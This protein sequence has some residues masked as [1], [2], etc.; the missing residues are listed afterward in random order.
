MEYNSGS[1]KPGLDWKFSIL[2]F[3]DVK[4]ATEKLKKGEASHIFKSNDLGTV[5]RCDTIQVPSNDVIEDYMVSQSMDV[6]DREKWHC[7][8]IYDGH[9]GPQTAA[10]LSHSLIPYVERALKSG[11]KAG[12][13]I[14]NAVKAAF[15]TLDDEM[16]KD[17]IAA[18]SDAATH[19]EV[20]AR[21]APFYAGSCALLAIYSPTTSE[22]TVAHV[23]DSRAVLG[24]PSSNGSTTIPLSADHTPYN[25]QELER[26]KTKHPNQNDLVISRDGDC[27]RYVGIAV[28]RAF[29]D[30]RW[31]WPKE[32]LKTCEKSFSG[33]P[34]PGNMRDPPY[35]EAEPD[36]K[37]IS[38]L[39][40]DFLILASDGLWSHLS[41]EDAVHAISLWTNATKLESLNVAGEGEEQAQGGGPAVLGKAEHISFWEPWK[42]GRESFVVE[43]ENAATHLV[44][45]AFGG[46]Q[47]QLFTGL[48]TLGAPTSKMMRD[49]VTVQVIFFG[50]I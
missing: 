24:R 31:K 47:R 4:T 38:I 19:A 26:I 34:P 36:V 21:L 12:D 45:N 22:L 42:V 17:G 35:I 40:G 2:P 18:L 43:D 30:A 6:G 46:K 11:L 14:E 37:T 23:G 7:W 44:K 28:T 25:P 49:D 16:S 27:D 48:M 3:L 41:S 32:Y 29:G 13:S 1:Q 10:L 9:A 50:D 39:P 15:M 8:A 20:Q 5:S 33:K